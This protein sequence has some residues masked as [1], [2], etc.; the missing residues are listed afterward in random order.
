LRGDGLAARYGGRAGRAGFGFV[1]A[2][3]GVDEGRAASRFFH[4]DAETLRGHPEGIE[5]VSA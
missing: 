5:Q 4:E 3:E 2:L 1:A